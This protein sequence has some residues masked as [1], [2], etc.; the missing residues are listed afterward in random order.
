MRG[1]DSRLLDSLGG[2][3]RAIVRE[4]HGC[5]PD[6]LAHRQKVG[7]PRLSLIARCDAVASADHSFHFAELLLAQELEDLLNYAHAEAHVLTQVGQRHFTIEVQRLQRNVLKKSPADASFLDLVGRN[8]CN[9]LHLTPPTLAW[10]KAHPA[11]VSLV[12]ASHLPID[13]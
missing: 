10:R 8:T 6:V 12:L 2:D 4:G 9:I 7:G 5:R 13:K 3:S 11:P 1:L